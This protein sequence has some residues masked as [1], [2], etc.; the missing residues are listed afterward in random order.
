MTSTTDIPVVGTERTTDSGF[1]EYEHRPVPDSARKSVF[2]VSSVWLGFP[3]ILTSAIFGGLVVYSLGFWMGMAAIATG[4]LILMT[5]VGLLSYQAGRT[6]ENFALMAARTFGA[7]GYRVPAAFLTTLVIGWFAFQ[8]GLTGAT[9]DAGLGWNATVVALLAGIGYIAVT[10]LGIRALTVIGVVAAPLYLALGIVAIVDA[11]DAPG[12]SEFTSYGGA[13]GSA[14]TFGAAVTLVVALFAD[15][16]TMTADFTRWSVNGRQ[17]F[18]AAAS[19][20]PV[21]NT[22]ALTVGGV[23]V[24]MGAAADPATSGGDFLGVLIDQGG[25]LVPIAVAFVF[26]NLGS[27]CTHCL[28]NGAV[29]WSQL[30]GIRMRILTAGLGAVGV[31]LAVAGIW[32]YFEDWLNLLGVVVPPLGAVL[33]VDQMRRR[34]SHRDSGVRWRTDSFVSWILGAG[35]ALATH[36]LLPAACVAVVGILVAG[37]SAALLGRSRR[38]DAPESA[39]PAT[40]EMTV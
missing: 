14:L 6:G 39:A 4:N 28:Y 37:T 13:A 29:G 2:A 7:I 31:A 11:A 27:V 33:I 16:G 35:A 32:Q 30:S 22:I 26:I 20:F 36:Y 15:S 17:A 19:A 21:G 25:V 3:M 8:T 23:I 24:A 5:Y 12:A 1:A 10:L 38:I 9:L 34:R 40:A 18:T